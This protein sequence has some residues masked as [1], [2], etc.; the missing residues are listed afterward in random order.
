MQMVDNTMTMGLSY[1]LTDYMIFFLL[2]M[3]WSGIK[4][5]FPVYSLE[6]YHL[7][8]HNLFCSVLEDYNWISLVHLFIHIIC[9]CYDRY[10]Q[11]GPS[12]VLIDLILHHIKSIPYFIFFRKFHVFVCMCLRFFSSLVYVFFFFFPSYAS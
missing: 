3:E 2:N 12:E 11:D 7:L 10:V 5:F 9:L 6:V 1:L 4:I 8:M